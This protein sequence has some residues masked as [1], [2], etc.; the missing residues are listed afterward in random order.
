MPGSNF[1]SSS[2][3][4]KEMNPSCLQPASSKIQQIIADEPF[5]NHLSVNDTFN[6]QSY[7]SLLMDN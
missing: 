3:F 2:S 6:F 5:K 4:E 1:F 7:N